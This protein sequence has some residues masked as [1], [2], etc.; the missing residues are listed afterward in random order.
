[1]KY[2]LVIGPTLRSFE[3]KYGVVVRKI[4]ASKPENALYEVVF[5]DMKQPHMVPGLHLAEISKEEYEA[6]LVLKI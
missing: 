5:E 4:K 6:H 3:G 2:V 1:M